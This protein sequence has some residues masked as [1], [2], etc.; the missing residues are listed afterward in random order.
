MLPARA[1][2]KYCL[3]TVVELMLKVS[4]GW[5]LGTCLWHRVHWICIT[6]KF[7]SIPFLMPV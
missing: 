6:P 3:L 7:V 5:P 2:F 1:S 4:E